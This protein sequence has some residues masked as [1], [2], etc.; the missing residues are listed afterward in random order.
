MVEHEVS[1]ATAGVCHLSHGR[2]TQVMQG[3]LN[4]SLNNEYD[5]KCVITAQ[6]E[7]HLKESGGSGSI[8]I[9]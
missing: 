1:V 2:H 4:K 6:Q 8:N 5:K 3:K 9:C 7:T